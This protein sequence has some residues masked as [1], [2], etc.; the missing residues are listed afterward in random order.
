MTIV[1]CVNDAAK[2][3]MLAGTALLVLGA[4]LWASGKMGLPL[5][6]LPGDISIVRG[7]FRFYFPL[8]T[9]LLLSALLT[10]LV[11]LARRS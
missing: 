7:N 11:W 2:L 3:L 4:I 8:V 9:S 10:L 6:R 1:G 5:G